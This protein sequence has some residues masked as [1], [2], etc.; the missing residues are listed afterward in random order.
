MSK[1]EARLNELGVKLPEIPTP[2]AN[3]LPAKRVGNLIYTAGQVPI[4]DGVSYKGK[5]GLDINIEES[6]AAA[7]IC[8][9]NCL[10]A[11]RSICP[12]DKI[13]TYAKSVT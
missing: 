9:I 13:R 4:Y 8:V 1:I 6:K 2:I 10:A 3:Y 7:K 11:I 12:L 5:L